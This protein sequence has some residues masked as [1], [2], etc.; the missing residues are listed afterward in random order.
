MADQEQT[1]PGT[2][3]SEE[4]A[5]GVPGDP[6]QPAESLADDA[7]RRVEAA[8]DVL[9]RETADAAG[10]ADLPDLGPPTIR[11]ADGTP[12]LSMLHDVDLNVT[13]E[14]GRT[15]MY[16]EDVVQLNEGSVIE[17]DKA[18]GDPVDVHVNGR[19]VARGEVLVLNDNFCIRVSEI[20]PSEGNG[21]MPPGTDASVAT[22]RMDP[23]GQGQGSE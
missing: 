7:L 23:A 9:R 13:I 12:D 3:P 15:R 17:L 5:N 1:T 2:G 22:N 20:V 18:A 19:R 6:G 21:M 11:S 10:N 8:A 4:H 16:V 14:L